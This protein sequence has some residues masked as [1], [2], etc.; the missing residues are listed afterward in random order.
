MQKLTNA[1]LTIASLRVSFLHN[2]AISENRSK[3]YDLIK[4]DY[5]TI[6]MPE[7]KTLTA[8]MSDCNF[9]NISGTSQ[10]SISTS[11]FT[12]V[13]A[14]YS[15][16]DTFWQMFANY[17][18]QFA[19]FFNLAEV[20]SLTS[21]FRNTIRLDVKIGADFSDYFTIGIKSQS[22]MSRKLVALDGSI[23]FAVANG[24]LD[25]HIQPTKNPQTKSYD[26]TQF[27]LKFVRNEK[28]LVDE[29]L[30]ALQT[31]FKEAHQHVEDIFKTSLTE[32]YWKS[33]E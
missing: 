20:V 16:V 6:L 29:G 12:Y 26:N 8:D 7:I 2:L 28:I 5:P 25:V 32:K 10:I 24:L 11:Y 22:E 9:Q 13:S 14:A 23:V 15:T 4:S 31:I 1:P 30:S 18:S 17:F 27:N 21:E 19:K 3:F 33:I